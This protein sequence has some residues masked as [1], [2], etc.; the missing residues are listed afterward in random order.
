M[1]LV[2]NLKVEIVSFVYGLDVCWEIKRKVKDNFKFLSL[3][4]RENEV[5]VFLGEIMF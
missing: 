3:S 1:N 5:V 4:S 2:Y